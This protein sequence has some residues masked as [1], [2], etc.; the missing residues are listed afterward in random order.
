M[1]DFAFNSEQKNN[2]HLDSVLMAN[3]SN[4]N[5]FNIEQYAS[6]VVQGSSKPNRDLLDFYQAN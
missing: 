5:T 4:L 1:M 2:S 3:N 6:G